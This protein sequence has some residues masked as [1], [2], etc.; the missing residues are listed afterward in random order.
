MKK[1]YSTI[2]DLIKSELSTDENP[3]AAILIK[4]LEHVKKNG[5]LT[6]DEF[7]KIAMW[8]SPRPKK[9]YLANSEEEI[10]SI[11]KKV[12]ST[13]FEK[14]KIELLDSLKGVRIPT[15]SAVLTLIDPKNYGMIDIR[16]WN[17]LYVYEYV[18]TKSDGKNLNADNWYN[19]LM[20]FRHYAK[21]FHVSARNIEQIL[22]L[23]HKRIQE[24]NLYGGKHN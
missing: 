14:R 13:D 22:F 4:E 20:L 9:H 18:R 24:G 5:Y 8:K 16:V 21:K 12:L 15:A 3:K 1:I 7:L 11:S 6:R 2:D 19:A 23:H 10:I 17:V